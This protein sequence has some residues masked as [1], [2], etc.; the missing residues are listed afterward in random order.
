MVAGSEGSTQVKF[1]G[2]GMRLK[3]G[4]NENGAWVF[5]ELLFFAMFF[6]SGDCYLDGRGF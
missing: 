1:G 4:R 2:L 6:D 5:T 3:W